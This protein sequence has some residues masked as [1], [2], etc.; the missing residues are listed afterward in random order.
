MNDRTKRLAVLIDADNASARHAQAIFAEISKIG[1]ADVRRVYGDFASGRL[2]AWTLEI[3][4]LSIVQRQCLNAVA[5]KNS[6][7]IALTMDAIDLLHLN[8]PDGFCLVS[9][10][11]DFTGL[12]QRLREEGLTVYGFGE[13]KT[14]EPFRN[15]CYRFIYVENLSDA[16]RENGGVAKDEPA[17]S[18]EPPTK[19]VPLIAA[20]FGNA[21]SGEWVNLGAVGNRLLAAA[22]DFDSRSYGCANL[23]TLAEKTGV[24]DL[25]K[26]SGGVVHIRRKPVR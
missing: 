9:S 24:F 22:P 17:S 16:A 6:A 19:A 18:K 15:A 12:A 4:S 8:R 13:R 23:S 21:N 25:R 7:D 3:K 10:D 26:D 11:S 2:S 1:R 14:P 20:A 5:G